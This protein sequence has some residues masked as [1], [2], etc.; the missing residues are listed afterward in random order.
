MNT[1]Y[2]YFDKKTGV[3]TDILK[4]RKRGRAKYV[5]TTLDAVLPLLSGERSML[6]LVVAYNHDEEQYVLLERDNVIKLRY[7]GKDQYKIPKRAIEDYDL[8]IDLYAEGNVIEV[9][10]D[11]SRMSTMYATD[12]REEVAFERGTEIRLYI[13]DKDG[14]ELLQTVIVDAQKLL[15]NGQLF[16]ELED[17]ID[18]NNISFYTDRVFD[19]YMWRK[20]KAKFLSPMKDQIRFEVQ[21]A[22]YKRKSGD[23]E[24]HLV[25]SKDADGIKIVNN[26]ENIKLV[27]LF[28][29]IEFYI[30]DR[31]DPSILHFKFVLKPDQFKAKEIL[32]ETK[33]DISGKG[34]LY[35]HKYISVLMEG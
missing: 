11:P 28:N 16:F 9:T 27:K 34:L 13:K 24:Y 15:E 18:Q 14:D 30:V 32:V 12:F 2:V 23:Y 21:K 20:G 19:N 29:N 25:V 10:I 4:V 17:H 26:I 7:Y 22:D 8:R 31:Y 35:N 5:T 6:D 3:I 1:R 33:E